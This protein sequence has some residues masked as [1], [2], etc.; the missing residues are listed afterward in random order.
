MVHVKWS[1]SR[2]WT[3]R[4]RTEAPVSPQ[5][6]PSALIRSLGAHSA[7]QGRE[8]FR[9]VRDCRVVFGRLPAQQAA[10]ENPI[11]ALRFG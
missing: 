4:A 7:C 8:S 2:L 3:A 11:M 1:R 6:I 10:R 5:D 9:R